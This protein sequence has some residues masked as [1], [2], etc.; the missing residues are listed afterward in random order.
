MQ[1]WTCKHVLTFIVKLYDNFIFCSTRQRGKKWMDQVFQ[2]YQRKTIPSKFFKLKFTWNIHQDIMI[3]FKK[4][5]HLIS[6]ILWRVHNYNRTF[7]GHFYLEVR[8]H[9]FGT[10]CMIF[11]SVAHNDYRSKIKTSKEA[12]AN[13]IPIKYLKALFKIFFLLLKMIVIWCF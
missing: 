9:N 12:K 5:V 8:N 1:N 2:D 4:F 10:N 11:L 3:F 7:T 6:E 13:L